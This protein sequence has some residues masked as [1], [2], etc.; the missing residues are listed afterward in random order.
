MRTREAAAVATLLIVMAVAGCQPVQPWRSELVSGNASGTGGSTG[1]PSAVVFSPDGTKIAFVT[2]ASDLGPSDT[3]DQQDVYLRDLVAGTTTL[4]SVNATGTGSGDAF[5]RAPTFSPDGTKVA[6]ESLSS[7]IDP[8]HPEGGTF[9]RDLIGGTTSFVAPETHPRYSPT[10]DQ[11]LVDGS[12]VYVIDLATE[13]RTL[14]SAT[15]GGAPGNGESQVP[16]FSPDGTKV[17]FQSYASDLVGGGDT[18]GTVDVFVRDLA[19]G[20]TTLASVNAAGDDSGVEHSYI[21]NPNRDVFNPDGSKVVFTSLASDLVPGD[22]NGG[23]DV[24]VRDLTTG[25][26]AFVSANE[27]GTGGGNNT[28]M[29]PNFSP[30]G[31]KVAFTSWASDLAPGSSGRFSPQVYVRDLEAGATVLASPNA[32]GTDGGDGESGTGTWSLGSDVFSPDG[33]KLA[34][35][36]T[37]ADLG[38][39]DTN[40]CYQN[41]SFGPCVDV[42]VRDL[43]T[44]A[45]T[46]VSA[47]AEG[48]DSGNGPSYGGVFSP[49]SDTIAF[50]SSA[51]NLGPADTSAPDVYLAT[52]TGADVSVALDASPG[53]VATGDPLAYTMGVANAGPDTAGGAGAVLQLPE[54]V[55]FAGVTTT[56]GSCAPP[57]SSSPRLVLCEFG[58][59][60]VGPVAEVTVTVAVTAPAGTTLTAE[61][62]AMSSTAVDPAPANNYGAAETTVS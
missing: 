56:A 29:Y 34:F 26:T 33:A 35:P 17:A 45:T 60:P 13:E 3:N 57:A 9:V 6:F 39:R 31:T 32:A 48:D 51:T 62:R 1:Y 24:F 16:T 61:A 21:G 49:V 38:P 5:S 23:F 2:D 4:V 41:G 22:T 8:A 43:R 15:P 44:G 30:D 55:T 18:N 25:S 37:A 58:D 47:D 11:V 53:A 20:V 28:S 7:D 12:Q 19:A 59:R 10:A 14:V 50:V 42:Y 52:L 36:S 46:L 40:E 27:S 54:G